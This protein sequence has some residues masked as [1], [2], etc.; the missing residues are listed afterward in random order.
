VPC[1]GDSKRPHVT[2]HV[3]R[4]VSVRSADRCMMRARENG[5]VG[6]DLHRKRHPKPTGGDR[7]ENDE[8]VGD[9]EM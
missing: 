3:A 1:L 5:V 4:T 6:K 8:K 9:K 7:T 2:W